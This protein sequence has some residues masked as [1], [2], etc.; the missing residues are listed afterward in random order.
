MSRALTLAAMG[1]G[2]VS[3]NPMVGCVIVAGETIIAEG[4][5]KVFG[6]PHAEVNAIN[7]VADLSILPQCTAYVNLEPCSHFGKTPPCVDLLI[8]KGLG[9]VVIGNHDPNPRVAGGGI[10]KL[11]KAGIPVTTGVMQEECRYL[12]RRFFSSMEKFR[13]YIILKWAQTEDGFIARPDYESRWI[14]GTEARKL[15]HKWRSE[16]DAAMVGTNTAHYD[17][18]KLNVRDWKGRDPV[19]VVIDRRLR[20]SQELNLFD[21]S[22]KTFCYNVHKDQQTRNLTYVKLEWDRFMSHTMDDLTKKGILSVMVEGGAT[23]LQELINSGLWDEIRLFQSPGVFEQGIA[24]PE[25]SGHL[26]EQLPVKD[27]VLNYYLNK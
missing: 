11:K 13:P 12:N 17:N 7:E 24:A 8:S 6:G 18:P 5:H 9:R 25:F 4:W 15:V 21:Q 3:P 22:Q 26:V 1:L 16:E 14:S 2:K 19:R 27:D 23:L 20:L 10:E